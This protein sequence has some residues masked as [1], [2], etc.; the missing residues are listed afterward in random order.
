MYVDKP[1]AT[2]CL[3]RETLACE[4]QMTAV[5]NTVGLTCTLKRL[6]TARR[7]RVSRLLRSFTIYSCS[8]KGNESKLVT[9]IVV[10]EQLMLLARY[11]GTPRCKAGKAGIGKASPISC[12]FGHSVD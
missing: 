1:V 11:V 9:S 3:N 5:L 6:F 7:F 8:S 2:R 12:V 4:S 10:V